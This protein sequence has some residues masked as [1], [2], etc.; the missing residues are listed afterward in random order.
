MK[1]DN[2]RRK[3]MTCQ[4]HQRPKRPNDKVEVTILR[5]GQQMILHLLM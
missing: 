1:L 5:D 4:I 2:Q 3:Y